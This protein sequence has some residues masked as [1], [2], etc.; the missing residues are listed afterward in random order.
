MLVKSRGEGDSLF[1]DF[2]RATD[3]VAAACALQQAFLVEPWPALTPLRVRMALHT[4]E[5]ERRVGDYYGAAVN[6]CARLR[7]IGHGGQ[8]LVSQSVY[9]I[10]QERLPEGTT[11]KDLG[12]HRLKDLSTPEH[13]WQMGHP[14]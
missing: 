10:T 8:V 2:A 9:D 13:V 1:I 3:A 7:A 12:L 6:R 11:L 4:G 14:A 5:A